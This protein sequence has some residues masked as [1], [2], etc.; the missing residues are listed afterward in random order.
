M[1]V[2]IERQ[3]QLMDQIRNDDLLKNG[4]PSRDQLIEFA[5]ALGMSVDEYKDKLMSRLRA[6]RRIS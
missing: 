6:F 5:T 4:I 3:N 2:S 1:S